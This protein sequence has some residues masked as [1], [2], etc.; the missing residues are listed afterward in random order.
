[1]SKRTCDNVAVVAND[2]KVQPDKQSTVIEDVETFIRRFVFLRENSLYTL[3]AVWVIA[4]YLTDLFDYTGYLFAYSPEPQS[5]KSRFLEVLNYLVKNPSSLLVAPT[6]AVLFRLASQKT[7]L[8]DEVDSWGNTDSLRGVL[9]SGFQRAGIVYRMREVNGEHLPEAHVV[10]GPKALAGIGKKILSAPTRDRTFMF[11]MVRQTKCEKR[12]RLSVRKIQ[13]E[14]NSLTKAI[15]KWTETNRSRVQELYDDAEVAIPYLSEFGDRTIDIALPLAAVIEVMYANSPRQEMA[16]STLKHAIALARN[17]QQSNTEQHKVIEQLLEIGKFTDYPI[18]G[19]PTEL[20]EQL[21]RVLNETVSADF[22]SI[23]LRHYGFEMKIRRRK[24]EEKPK[25]RY[26]LAKSEL[27]EI[28]SRYGAR[29][30]ASSH[31]AEGTE[32]VVAV[33]GDTEGVGA[34]CMETEADGE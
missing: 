16:R 15:L 34:N 7:M 4:T 18:V 29:N 1:M 24:G 5:G 12:E 10:F 28:I 14:A 2:V 23:T 31:V 6:E 27:E 8:L 22:I 11:E 9:N 32:D 21:N 3:A 19:N 17:E 13:P 30:H 33:V 26:V 20:A 25:Y